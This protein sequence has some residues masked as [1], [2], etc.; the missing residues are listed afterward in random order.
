VGLVVGLAGAVI[1]S[2]AL[3]RVLDEGITRSDGPLV[4][5][6]SVSLVLA[7]AVASLVPARRVLGIPVAVVL[8]G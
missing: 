6:L 3:Q 7:T 2:P 8:R 1:G 4:A 5:V